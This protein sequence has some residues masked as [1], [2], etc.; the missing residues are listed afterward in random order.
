[1]RY[2]GTHLYTVVRE[3]YIWKEDVTYYFKSL[4][5]AGDGE[6]TTTANSAARI[7]IYKLTEVDL[8]NSDMNF[9]LTNTR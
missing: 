5:T 4:N 9:V 8:P 6:T 1:M 2:D 3:G 7:D